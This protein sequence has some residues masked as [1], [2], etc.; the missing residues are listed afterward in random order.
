MMLSTA[1]VPALIDPVISNEILVVQSHQCDRLSLD[2]LKEQLSLF[3]GRNPRIISLEE[4]THV[5]V[6]D[7]DIIFLDELEQ[8]ILA[9]LSET[10]YRAIQILC[11]T[12]RLLWVVSGA[13][14]QSS[15]PESAMAIGL[16]R[17]IRTEIPGIKFVTLDLDEKQKLSA[18]RTSEVI[19]NFFFSFFFQV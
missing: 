13:Q 16:A 1:K 10:S 14:I 4:L 15:T 11:T 19:A 17:C 5:D 3:T 7:S 12:P 18:K 6:H 2:V 8:P 9:H